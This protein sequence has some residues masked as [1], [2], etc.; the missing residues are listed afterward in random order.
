MSR[1]RSWRFFN[2]TETGENLINVLNMSMTEE[3]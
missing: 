2:T 3:Y 1:P